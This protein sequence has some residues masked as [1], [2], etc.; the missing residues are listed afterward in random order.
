MADKAIRRPQKALSPRF[1]ETVNEP[2][3]YFDGQGLYLRV[4]PNGSRQWVQRITIRGK[5]CEMGLGRGTQDRAAKAA[6]FRH[7]LR[8]KAAI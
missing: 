7:A 6:F 5:R 2:G 1:V 8:P 3:K 4:Q